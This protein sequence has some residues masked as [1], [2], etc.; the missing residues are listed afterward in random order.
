[1]SQENTWRQLGGSRLSSAMPVEAPRTLPFYRLLYVQ[2]LLASTL[3]VVALFATRP[4]SEAI[5]EAIGGGQ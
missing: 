5:K 4:H 2:V 3:T 1:M